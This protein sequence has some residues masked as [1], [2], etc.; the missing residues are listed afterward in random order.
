MTAATIDH[1][2]APGELGD[3]YAT[4][5]PVYASLGWAPVPLPPRRKAEPPRGST[6]RDVADPTLEQL[7]AWRQQYPNGNVALRTP[8]GVVGVD[9][10]QYLQKRGADHLA[11]LEAELGQ[12]PPTWCSS[13]RPAP[14]GIRWYRVRAGVELLGNPLPDV[15]L[16]QR[17]HRYAVVAP[18]E[19]PT[20]GERYSWRAPDGS[21]SPT[22]PRPEQLPELP[23]AYLERWAAGGRPA[24][25]PPQPPTQAPVGAQPSAAV[26]EALQGVD[27]QGGRHDAMTALTARLAR[28]EHEGHAGA[29]EALELDGPA[30]RAFAAVLNGERDDRAEWRRAVDGARKLVACTVPPGWV[31]KDARPYVWAHGQPWAD[32]W[33]RDARAAPADA[34]PS[35]GLLG[36]LR[37]ERLTTAQ[38][39]RLPPP[40]PLVP[41]WINQGTTN[42]LY[43]RPKC[44]KT[45]VSIDLALSLATGQRWRNVQ[46]ERQ[47]VL[48]LIGEGV[49]T[50]PSRAR[51]WA[52]QRGVDL[53]APN[54]L[55][56]LPVSFTLHSEL[57]AAELAA[58]VADAE[59]AMR[60]AG[61]YR[62]IVFDTLARYSA[63]VDENTNAM[64]IVVDRIE[65][66]RR[67]AAPEAAALIVHHTNVAGDKRSRGHGATDAAVDLGVF[68]S[69][70]DDQITAEVMASRS[71]PEGAEH[72]WR[73]V[74]VP[75]ARVGGE[76]HDPPT[77][78]PAE[79]SDPTAM[80]KSRHQA[81]EALGA[82]QV[83]DEWISSSRWQE[84]A[85]LEARTFHRAKRD[86]VELELVEVDTRGRHPKYRLPQGVTDSD[87]E[88]T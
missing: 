41:G 61:G 85:E 58:F 69:K 82:V 68:V 38:L 2:T 53:D 37:A 44:G 76:E 23:A 57:N 3:G 6:G 31:R 78:V 48:Y 28:L 47:P 12:L 75:E 45:L 63:G 56:V 22:P 40:V 67:A 30:H 27:W 21:T 74:T 1:P 29:R 4:A 65:Q 64:Q 35:S 33:P 88:V 5:A 84:S 86:L 50:F 15:E 79:R 59:D 32:Q 8:P 60:P 52:Y 17:H 11:E 83:A 54:G 36:R 13:A 80:P 81:L 43:G 55:T 16:V 25:R 72:H 70:A 24:E 51:A 49:P 18:S 87:R 46:L 62:L 20:T 9:V 39:L 26:L 71:G 34:E 73:L 14:S 77:V 66:V 42:I 10:D 19:H 7:D